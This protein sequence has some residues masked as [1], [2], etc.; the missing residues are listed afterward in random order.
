MLAFYTGK[1]DLAHISFVDEA[2][3]WFPEAGRK[4]GFTLRVDL[5]LDEAQCRS[6]VGLSGRALSRYAARR[7]GAARGLSQVHGGRRRLDGI[8][9]CRLCADAF[10]V[11][12]EL[13]LVSQ[14]VSRRRFVCQQHLASDSGRAARRGTGTSG[15]ERSAG[16]LQ[17]GAERMVPLGEGPARESATSRSS[18]RSIRRAF[19][20]APA[21]SRTRS[22]TAATIP[23]CGPTSAIA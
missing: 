10:E 12:A 9:F 15:D 8:P 6:S 11:P 4:N 5:R 13:G 14:R 21:P 16:H 20:S 18:C 22:G 2:N 23:W 17:L 3:K 7:A 1:N 19:R